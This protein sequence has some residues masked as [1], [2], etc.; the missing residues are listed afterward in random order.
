MEHEVGRARPHDWVSVG[1][2][3]AGLA[4]VGALA[5]GRA[6]A[7][8]ACGVIAVAA[9]LAARAS[10]RRHPAPMPYSLRW[11]LYAPRWPLSVAR[12]CR[13][14]EPRAGERILEIGPGVGIY[15]LP[16]AAELRPA[17][18]LDALDV[19][20]EMLGAL[21]RRAARAG[22]TNVVPAEGNAQRLPYPEGSFDAAYLVGVLGEIPDPAAALREL[23]RVLK[24]GGRL[25]VGEALVV[26]PD[27]VRFPALLEVARR[28]GFDF[29]RRLG[30]RFAYFARLR[31]TNA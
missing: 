27:A 30:P 15:S 21:A 5:A 7:A 10:S 24:P 13:I 1:G 14:L 23:R 18:V 29:E 6:V 28:A 26:D 12:L 8:V 19:Q 16:I 2:A 11:V 25:V 22:A 31:P 3:M 4:A 9:T 20:R 17:G